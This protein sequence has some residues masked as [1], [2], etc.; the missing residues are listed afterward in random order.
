MLSVTFYRMINMKTIA[1]IAAAGSGSRMKSGTSKQFIELNG[2]PVLIRTLFAF[3]KAEKID[4]VIIVTRKTDIETVK[5]M[6]KAYGIK[7]VLTIAVGGETRQDS[8][9]NA[10]KVTD[11][12]YVLIHD[13]A[14]PFITPEQINSVASALS[15]NDA[16]ALGK[17]VT[18][19][20]KI[21]ENGYIS[22]TQERASLYGIQTPQ[23][24]KTD[25]IKDAHKAAKENGLSVTDDCALCEHMGIKIKII[26]GSSSNIKITTPDDLPIA[27]GILNSLEGRDMRIGSGYDVHQ[28][29]ENRPLIM[30]GVNIPYELGLLGH[31][32]ADVLLHAIMD[33]MLGAAAL[34]DIGKHFPDTD[35]KW[36]GADSMKL[37]EAVNI[38][39]K[40]NGY[41]I[42]NIDATIIAQ[43]PKMAEFIPHMRENVASTLGI[44]IDFVNIKATTTEKLGFCGRGEGIAAEA[45][46]TIK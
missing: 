46:C 10:L 4:G 8:V 42:H 22:G 28:L 16:A 15:E 41:S 14:R 36:K 6:V 17:P 1:I 24:F 44:P 34:G 39:L 33:A 5:D 31:S 21:V 9:S 13:G 7:K 45:V 27:M 3:D 23:G 19:T 11:S 25:V 2:I 35:A 32:D 43:K 12:E 18:D 26:E 40:S 37:L 29:I 20:L 30:G 38:L